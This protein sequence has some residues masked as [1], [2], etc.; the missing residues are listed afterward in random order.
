MVHTRFDCVKVVSKPLIG[1]LWQRQSSLGDVPVLKS[2]CWLSIALIYSSKTLSWVTMRWIIGK[3]SAVDSLLFASSLDSRWAIFETVERTYLRTSIKASYSCVSDCFCS[4]Y[5]SRGFID[6][7]ILL[8]T[9]ISREKSRWT[10]MGKSY[11][12]I[13]PEKKKKKKK[14][15]TI[16]NCGLKLNLNNMNMVKQKRSIASAILR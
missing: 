4:V 15:I 3:L 1:V 14:R 8:Q 16:T 6:A 7:A 12:N 9:A 5:F 13:V 10:C 2:S 11:P